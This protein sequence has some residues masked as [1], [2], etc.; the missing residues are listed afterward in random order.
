MF[1][2][3]VSRRRPS[4]TRRSLLI[5]SLVL[6]GAVAL[7]LLV[8]SWFHVAELTPPLLAV[9]F[10]SAAEPPPQGSSAPPKRRPKPTRPQPTAHSVTPPTAPPPA[11]RDEGR[12]DPDGPD[13]P[14]VPD[15]EGPPGDPHSTRPPCVGANCRSVDAPAPRPRN[16]P[17]HALDA[18]RL[19]GAMPHLPSSVIGARRGLGE[20]TFTAR[21][22]VDQSGAV[23]SVTVLS[24]IPGAD[25]DIVST[26]RNWRY[27]P[28]AIPVCFITQLVYNVE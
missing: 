11:P 8:G 17:P 5:G 26:L 3:F 20:S 9:V 25:G 14:D 4:W 18:Q 22:C 27:K 1:D 28:Q 21:L 2:R 7:A 15:R 19:A 6:H 12:R 24:G 16:L 13:G 10:M 23:S